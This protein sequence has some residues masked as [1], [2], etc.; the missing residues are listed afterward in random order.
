MENNIPFL[1]SSICE[2]PLLGYN[3]EDWKSLYSL[4]NSSEEK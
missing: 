2:K 3:P 4:V 1:I